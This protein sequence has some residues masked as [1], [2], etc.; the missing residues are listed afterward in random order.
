MA[1]SRTRIVCPGLAS[2]SAAPMVVYW[3][4]PS[5]ATVRPFAIVTILGLV[6]SDDELPGSDEFAAITCDD[7]PFSELAAERLG[8]IAGHAIIN[9]TARQTAP[10]MP[11]TATSRLRRLAPDMVAA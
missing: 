7:E 1:E 4:V 3:P 5:C 2:S 9:A 8:K 6:D 11:A 10:P